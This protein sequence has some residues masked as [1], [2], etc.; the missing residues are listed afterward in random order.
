LG[1][2]LTLPSNL[3]EGCEL[4]RAVVDT[5]DA[6]EKLHVTI[7]YQQVYAEDW[8]TH[9]ADIARAMAE[10]HSNYLHTDRE[11]GDLV[12]GIRDGFN[13]AFE[14]GRHPQG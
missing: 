12:A 10:Q 1:W 7:A 11:D 6:K 8:G 5:T 2:P 9:L 3:E 13:E 4:I 14:Q